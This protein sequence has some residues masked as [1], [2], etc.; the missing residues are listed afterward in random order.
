[1]RYV[2]NWCNLS[3]NY[4]H[5]VHFVRFA[6]LIPGLFTA[7][8][9]LKADNGLGYSSSIYTRQNNNGG[10]NG[11]ECPEERDYYPYWHPSPWKDIAVLVDDKN[12][13]GLVFAKFS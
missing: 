5:K 13:C 2:S 9:K 8:Q 6:I 4:K 12:L 11:Y 1:M 10:R 7:D 3:G